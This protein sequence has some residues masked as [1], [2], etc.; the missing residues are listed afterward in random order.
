MVREGRREGGREGGRE[1]EGE[2]P[3]PFFYGPTPSFSRIFFFL[4]PNETPARNKTQSSFSL[5]EPYPLQS[6]ELK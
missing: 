1:G 4:T 2:R 3:S 5:M 6:R